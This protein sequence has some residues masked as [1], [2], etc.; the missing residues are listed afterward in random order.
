MLKVKAK[1]KINLYLDVLYKRAD[2]YH[3]VKMVM[4]SV[5]LADIIEL[6]PVSEGISV[7]S[8]LPYLP[9][10]E[11]NLAYRA[12]VLLQE[13]YNVDQGVRIYLEKR[14]PV[15]AGLAGGSTDAAAV[16]MALNKLWKLNLP[17]SELEQLAAELGSDVPFC[18]YGGT[19]LAEGRGELIT[20]LPSL[21]KFWTVIATPSFSVSTA[22]VYRSLDLGRLKE[23]KDL[24]EM[25]RGLERDKPDLIVKNLYNALETVTAERYEEINLLKASALEEGA[26][27]ALMSGSGPSVFALAP[28]KSVA[29]AIFR[30]WKRMEKKVFVTT[31]G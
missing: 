16:L 21:G 11:R 17:L 27:A 24:A 22:E 6:V 5:D 26:L 2:G 8:D 25:I 12:A 1:A 29:Q 18:L 19:A 7:F 15:A 9:N 28:S 31:T 23:K 20:P 10:D 13:K 4:Q 30:R 3:E 14:I